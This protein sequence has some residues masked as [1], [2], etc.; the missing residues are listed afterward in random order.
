MEPARQKQV[1]RLQAKESDRPRRP[2]GNA[3]R[4]PCPPVD[5]AWQIDREDRQTASVQSLNDTRGIAGQW[6]RQPCAEQRIDNEIG[7]K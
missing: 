5:P 2:D 3:L 1:P 4:R 6:P 7:R